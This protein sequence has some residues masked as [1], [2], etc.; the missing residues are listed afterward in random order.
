MPSLLPIRF[1]TELSRSFHRDIVSTL[2]V[3]NDELNTLNTLDTTSY[4]YTVDESTTTITGEDDKGKTLSYIPGRIEVFIDGDKVDTNK[5]LANDGDTIILE[6]PTGE[7]ELTFSIL[8]IVFSD[9]DVN[10]STDTISYIAHN[11]ETGDVIVYKKNSGTPIVGLVDNTPYYV[12]KVTDDAFK[13]ASNLTN[14]LAGTQ[15]DINSLISSGSDYLFLP[16]EKIEVVAAGEYVNIEG[17][18]LSTGDIVIYRPTAGTSETQYFVIRYDKN[19]FTLATTLANAN[20]NISIDLDILGADFTFL[21]KRLVVNNTTYAVVATSGVNTSTDVITYTSH[22]FVTGDAVVYSN[23]GGTSITGL[24]SGSTYYVYK[25][26]ESTF[27]LYTTYANSL[28]GGATGLLDLSGTG[29]N[30]QYFYLQANN[31]II[32]PDHGLATG[33]TVRYSENTGSINGLSDTSTYYVIKVNENAIKLTTSLSNALAD[34]A[35]DLLTPVQVATYTLQGPLVQTVVVN[36]F[37]IYNYPNPRDYF[38]MF[39][40]KSDEWDVETVPPTPIDSRFEESQVKRNILGVKKINASDTCLLVRRIDWETGTVYDNYDDS[41]DL[42]DLDFYV[43]NPNNFR[44]YKCLD[45]N[46]G[47]P[48]TVLPSFSEMGP[49]TLSDGYVWQLMYEVPAADRTKFLNDEYIPVKF[50]GTSTRFDHNGT[51][52]E[53]ILDSTGA[54]YTSTPTVLI[55][56]DGVGAT[57]QATVQSGLVT[58]I[59]LTNGG[60]GYS[61]AFVQFVGG[62]GSGATATAIIETTDLPNVVNQNVAGYAVASSGQIDFIKIIDGGSGYLQGTTGVNIVGN[63]SGAAAEVT[64][65]EG[66]ITEVIITDRGTNYTFA[67]VII[68]GDGV[69]ADLRTVISPQGGHGSNIPQELLATTLGI[70]LNIEDFQ[71]DFFLDND[72][73]QYG[74]IK[75]INE[76]GTDTFLTDNTGNGCFVVTVPDD[77]QYNL[78]DVITTDGGGK[79]TVVYV[80]NNKIYLLPSIN[81]ITENSVLTNVT[82]GISNLPI[83]PNTTLV[84][85][86]FVEPDITQNSGNII[87][88]NNIPPLQRQDDQTETI[89]MYINF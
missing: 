84:T 9:T 30:S 72:F 55:L 66:V 82:T 17:H 80:N 70:S 32:I 58:K 43:F 22:P 13:V 76:Y 36:T 74:I 37:T 44:L 12:I 56:G 15:V 89:K 88:L 77:T 26:T 40:A 35:I 2:N 16:Y 73:R 51:V 49:K 31:Q 47:N 83:L 52:T 3:P 86:N 45:N 53:L 65:V 60:V 78:D 54:S 19:N 81:N 20:A 18:G 24:T 23:A 34:I 21:V 63:G 29:N 11:L 57:A 38:F 48:S 62:G 41:V 69:D 14:A 68:T 33:Q 25:V 10:S 79:F 39:L 42:S 1:R 8:G 67:D 75:N 85:D 87:F 71:S 64:V 59:E 4:M 61:F 46:T 6:T 28:L 7:E 50:Y 27:K 5:F